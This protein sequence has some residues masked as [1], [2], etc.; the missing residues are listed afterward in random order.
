MVA[1]TKDLVDDVILT[2]R[3]SKVLQQTLANLLQPRSFL[4]IAATP[5]PHLLSLGLLTILKPLGVTLLAVKLSLACSHVS[6]THRTSNLCS[7]IKSTTASVLLLI[8]LAFNTPHFK[9]LFIDF[10]FI[11]LIIFGLRSKTPRR[12]FEQENE[13]ASMAELHF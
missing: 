10:V 13:K 4:I 3:A 8:D 7:R 12:S 2:K 5:P 1:I 6:V 11:W 9:L